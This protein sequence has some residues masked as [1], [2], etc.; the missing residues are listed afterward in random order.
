MHSKKIKEVY[1]KLAKGYNDEV[2]KK[3]KYV[4]HKK[5]GM[6]ISNKVI[7]KFAKILDLGCGTGLSSL[8]FFK[9]GYEVTG[10]DIAPG[11]ISQAKKLPYEKLICQ[12]LEVPLRVNNNYYDAVV[13]TGVMEFIKKPLKI[14]QQV[15]KKL[16]KNGICGV[17]IPK[18]QSKLEIQSYYKKEIEPVF[19]KAGFIIVEAKSIFGYYKKGD[20]NLRVNYYGYV[21]RKK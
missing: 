6:L 10:I 7:N 9:R 1:S 20:I 15:N 5:I 3:A 21:L 19:R 12:D 18:K 4:A 2:L 8:E 13:L 11:M 14:F 17:T 16:V